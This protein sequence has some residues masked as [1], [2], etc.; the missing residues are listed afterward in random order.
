MEGREV[1]NLRDRAI[2][3][4]R[5]ADA[6]AS[7]GVVDREKYFVVVTR[8]GDRQI[9][10]VVD[11][12]VR[13]QEIVIKSIGERLKKM[14]G[15]AGA[16]EIGENEIVLVVDVGSLIENFGSEARGRRKG[17]PEG[18]RQKPEEKAKPEVE[19]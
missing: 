8:S 3:L 17:K 2:P 11:S 6:F 13:Q 18:R 16:T 10:L 5:L 1:F 9:G 4:L 7:R 15:I 14:P 12:L 19:S